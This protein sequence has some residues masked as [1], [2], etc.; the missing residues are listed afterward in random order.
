MTNLPEIKIIFEDDH[1]LVIDKPAGLIVHGGP[2]IEEATLSDWLLLH[3]PD[4]KAVGDDPLRPGLVQ[5]LDKE[6]SGLMVIAKTQVSFTDLKKQFKDRKVN[7]EY[8]ALVHGNPS[9]KSGVIT[10]PIKRSSRGY[11]MAAMPLGVIDLVHRPQ[12]KNRDQGN[13]EGIF[14]A[15]EAI[16]EY[17]VLQNFINHSLVRVKIKTGRTHQIRVHFLALGHPLVGDDLYFNKKSKLRNKKINLG[18]IFLVADTLSFL[19]LTGQEK[20]FNLDLPP[21]LTELLATLK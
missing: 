8:L 19:T 12:P 7:K 17:Q 3:Y 9:Q 21:Q 13:L 4:I 14:K 2:G 6:V 5:R 20:T 11:K 1:Y 16:T 10:F 18:R 15:R